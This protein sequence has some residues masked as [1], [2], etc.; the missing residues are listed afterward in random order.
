MTEIVIDRPPN[1]DRIV[2][3][4]P[5]AVKPGVIFAYGDRIYNPSGGVIPAA[6][7]RHEGVHCNRQL[8]GMDN[9]VER[10]WERY[11]VDAEFRYQE[12]LK[13][14]VAEYQ[15]QLPGLDRNSR[16]KLLMATA[17]RL[18]APLYNY[19]PPRSLTTAMRDL[20][21]ELDR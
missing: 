6:L 11:L 18:C 19:Q 7:M 16:A 1:F 12:E 9:S 15:A 4:F 2:A 14:H 20:R 8:I 17:A 13:A 5:D 3:A 21:W 10:W